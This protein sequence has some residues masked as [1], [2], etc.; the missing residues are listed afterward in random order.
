MIDKQF[1]HKLTGQKMIVRKLIGSIA[2][3]DLEEKDYKTISTSLVVDIAIVNIN[4]LI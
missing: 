2:T 3:C 4:K 1:T